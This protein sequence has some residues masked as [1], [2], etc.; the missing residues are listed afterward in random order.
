MTIDPFIDT[1]STTLDF[2]DEQIAAFDTRDLGMADTLGTLDRIEFLV[3]LGFVA[4][5]TY[6]VEASS[7]LG[8]GKAEALSQGP[9]H[10]AGKPVVALV[11]AAAN[12]WKHR[13]EWD[14]SEPSRSRERV[15]ESIGLLGISTAEDYVSFNVLHELVSPHKD[16]FSSLIPF[17]RQWYDTLSSAGDSQKC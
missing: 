14:Y 2:F 11:N 12:C 10:V 5:Q 15:E 4:C 13:S 6:L 1:L 7:A 9:V 16:A 17:L 8:L 3:G